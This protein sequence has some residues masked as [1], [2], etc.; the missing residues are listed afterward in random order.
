MNRLR[1]AFSMLEM[2]I[3]LLVIGMIVSAIIVAGHMMQAARLNEI[4]TQMSGY[5]QAVE[6]FRLKYITFPGDA[7]NATGFWADTANGDGDDRIE[8]A[9]QLRAWQHL[10]LSGFIHGSYTGQDAGTPDYEIDINV[11]GSTIDGAYYI[12][13]YNEV[14]TAT[15][16]TF[17]N[18]VQ[19]V[20]TEDDVD[21]QG[22]AITAKEARMID[23]KLD[24]SA[25]PAGGSLFVLRSDNNKAT[26]SSCVDQNYTTSSSA[27][28]VIS[29]TSTSCRLLLWLDN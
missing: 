6:G 2:S 11:P 16:G 10:Q 5:R 25:N 21:P 9:E 3:V 4:I 15:A 27:S 1:S 20:T 18:N 26:A 22:G 13:S 14:Y 23:M 8:S 7:P 28:Y 24:G 12:L 29:D 19:L 17:G